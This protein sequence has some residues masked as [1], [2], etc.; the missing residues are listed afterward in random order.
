MKRFSIFL[1]LLLCLIDVGL[2][3][4][5]PTALP[6]V[7]DFSTANDLTLVN[8]SQINKWEYGSATGNAASSIYISNNG[9]TTN[10]Y[11]TGNTSIVHAYKDVLI[12]AG[13]TVA[14]LAFD[15]KAG[16]ESTYDYLRVWQVPATFTPTAGTQITAGGGNIQVGQFNQQTTWQTYLSTTLSVN[17]F[18]GN[19]MRLVFEW[20][21]DDSAGTQPPVAIDNINLSI[22]TCLSPSAPVVS[23]VTAT[24]ATLGWTAPTPAPGVGYEYYFSTT[25]TPPTAA[26]TGTAATGISAT[27]T[28]LLPNTTY[29]WW[30]R[31]VCSA[32][33]KSI[34]IAGS[35]FTTTQV[36]ATI[37]Y[38]QDFST[39]N[40]FG[41]SNGTQPNKWVY[42]S[43]TGNPAG[44]IYISDNGT[45]N[46]YNTGLSS[47]TQAYKDILVP[48]GTTTATLSFNWKADGE[49]SYDYLR[50][51]LVPA[52]FT[53]T[54][55][56]QITTGGGRIQLGNNYNQQT[57]WQTFLDPA[58]DISSFAGATMRLV[59]EW[60]NDSSGGTQPPVGIDN[61]SLS[62]PTCLIP[63]ALTSSAITSNSATLAWTA[64]SPA[65]ANGYAYYISTS[66][67]PPVAGTAPSGTS[68]GTSVTLP[69]LAP[70]TTYY[71]WVK[72]VCS[73]TDSSI[74]VS[75]TNFTTTQIPATIPYNQNFSGAND[76]GFT[77]GSQPNKWVYGSAAGNPANSIYISDNGT[78]NNYN[79]GLTSVTQA[80]R[81]I[82]VPA[83]TTAATLSFDWKADGESSYDYLRVWLV[84]ASYVPTAGVQIP[85]GGG[86]IQLGNNYNQQTSWQT[87]FNTNL[88]LSTF[89]GT[90][91]RLVFEWRNDSS[92]GTQ[93]PAAIDNINLIIPTCKVPTAMS[94]GTITSNSATIS[95]TAPSP[96]PGM[97]YAYYLTTTNVPPVAGTA[98]TGTSTGTSVTLPSLAPN[99]T[100]Y[101]WVKSVCSSTD[102]SLWVAGP[103]FTTTQ[104]PATIP[105][106]QNFSGANDFGFSNGTQPNKWVY[107]SATGNPANSIYISDNG[108]ANNYNTGLSS[109]TQA[110]RDILVPVGA[111]I[112]TLS[113]DWKGN[114]ESTYDYLRVWLVPA[115]FMPTAGVQITAGTGRI[116]LG[117]N[118]NQQST[119]QSYL[120]AN[121]NISSFAGTTMRLVFEWRNDSSGG[122][123]PPAAVDNVRLIICSTA[124]PTVTVSGITHNAA[125]ITWPQDIGGASYNVRYRPVG[126]GGAWTT[127]SVPAVVAPA[128]TNSYSLTNLL[129]AT[130]YEVEVAAVC[131][132][133]PGNYSHN[134]FLTRCDPTPPNVTVSNI[135]TTSA[136]ITWA[137]L[138][139]SSSYKMRY[140]IVGS[141]NTGWSADIILPLAPTNTY[142]L[143]GLNVYTTYEVQVAN[144]CDNETTYNGWSSPAV[145]TTERT[146]DL[147][148]PGL[149]I[150]NLT[151]ITAT[152]IWDSFPGAT[153][154]LRYRKVGIPSWTTVALTNNNYIITG[155]TE[156]TKYEMEVANVCNGT[157]GTYTPPYYF[158]TPT[159]VYCQMS[160]GNSASEFI[161]KVT[162]KPTGKPTMENASD[163]SNYS[164]FTGDP[165]KFIELIQGSTG[166]EISIEKSWTGNNYDEGIAVWIDFDRNGSFDIDERILV[167]SPN[168]T[169]PVK[170]T[171]NV[172]TDAFISTTD[173]KYVV[174]RVAMQREGIPVNCLSF[175]NGEVEDYT[176]RISKNPVPNATNQ[177]DILIYPNPVSTVLNVKN[178]SK[179]ANYKLYNAAG[180]LVSSGIILNNKIDV[181]RLING[182]YVIDIEDVQG[183][184]QKKFIKE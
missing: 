68:T 77:N 169:T 17:S 165:T 183:S 120:N 178:I 117:N 66:S 164:D 104:I 179:R 103:T 2:Y 132:S 158:T 136:L 20:V 101:W 57:S 1:I 11:T 84:P 130:L 112:A 7:Q 124:T 174:M 129:P 14:T 72:S 33:D 23:A 55:G 28:P 127:V 86:R 85:T 108:T 21:N 114:G 65:P 74:W 110:Y 27:A 73:P 177:T 105:Y 30:V 122:T 168:T 167:S 163:A 100:Y 175:A 90:T 170:G 171:F 162:V 131:N 44:S 121:L 173:Y 56:T 99:T 92:G 95:W 10:A 180:Q 4:Q 67:T 153:Y 34:W 155:L 137:P 38:I 3:A 94:V 62:I 97:G 9:G 50:V 89:A 182:V 75:G 98:P 113:F 87:Y 54:A 81:D 42:G 25:N 102:S 119:W 79:T 134:E 58:L 156:L 135:T 106:N 19:T 107:G 184:A 88:D 13:S 176:V 15:W 138:A 40:D 26:T 35:N 6:Y 60:R 76:F 63:T 123:Q 52:T 49:S 172:P 53:P 157:P 32:T 147:P 16:G 145:F 144:K 5:G 149:T 115:S 43:A 111:S 61:I 51:W 96:A 83:G 24:T 133:I 125:N 142:L 46:N 64:P 47:I 31:S 109:V 148:P 139:T 166:N 161:S 70:N 140:R 126:S 154:I 48:A 143:P 69:S 160:S 45:A 22:P 8:G 18:A 116:Q 12:P 59:F 91:M 118:Y 78:A 152:V 128:T 80:Y 36:A 82:A 41:F 141:G 29:Y 150:T 159:V 146:C 37:P 181:S 39:G 93:P 151:P 71:W